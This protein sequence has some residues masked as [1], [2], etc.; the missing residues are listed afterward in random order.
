MPLDAI[1]VHDG[2]VLLSTNGLATVIGLDAKVAS[3]TPAYKA[4]FATCPDAG[5]YRKRT[6]Q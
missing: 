2:N 1:P 5:R 4:H 6:K 3:G